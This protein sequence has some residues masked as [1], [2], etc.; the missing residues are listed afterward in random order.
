MLEYHGD[1][2]GFTTSSANNDDENEKNVF[3]ST[4][5]SAD[6]DDDNETN[7]GSRRTTRKTSV[8]DDVDDKEGGLNLK[9]TIQDKY[10][11]VQKV[12][13]LHFQVCNDDV[14]RKLTSK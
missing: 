6:N 2:E 12:C 8:L 14:T 4:T 10:G 3:I 11:C 1:K 7:V 13:V 9:S 5:S